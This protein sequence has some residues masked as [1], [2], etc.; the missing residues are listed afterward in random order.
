MIYRELPNPVI[1]VDQKSTLDLY[2]R[3]KNNYRL[4][5]AKG[6]VFTEEHSRLFRAHNITLYISTQDHETANKE[7][8]GYLSDIL[9]DPQVDS[10]VKVGIIYS[11]SVKSIR[12]IF[13]AMNKETLAELERASEHIAKTILFDKRVI[14]NLMKI[15]THDHFIYTHSV[16]VGIY[17]T[18]LCINLFGD[19]I[20]KHDINN[21]STA[22]LLHDIGMAKVP[23][24]IL[25]KSGQLTRAE[26]EVIRKHPVWGHDKL[27]KA[28]YVSREATEVILFH[29]ERCNNKGYPFMK[30]AR[31]I[32]VYAKI[33]AV[34]DTFES[35]TA[36]RPQ[37]KSRTPFEALSIMQQE[38]T[39][40]FDPNVFKAFIMLLGPGM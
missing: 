26:V 27:M 10:A 28:R 15:N 9:T 19:K 4:F 23:K 7:I 29:H 22:F 32:P 17:G 3:I 1:C 8:N 11:A 31:D 5:A 18:A 21:L 38:M 36:L 14:Q 20:N 6:A 33:C 24:S 16:K 34:A 37:H 35:I 12:R 40:E 25:D 30:S 13:Q 39:A 2:V